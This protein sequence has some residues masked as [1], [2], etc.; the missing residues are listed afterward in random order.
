[1]KNKI[2]RLTRDKDKKIS[3]H[4]SC[5]CRDE[6]WGYWVSDSDMVFLPQRLVSKLTDKKLS[7]KNTEPTEI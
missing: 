3:L 6:E 7:W 4:S 5:P 1:M 2:F